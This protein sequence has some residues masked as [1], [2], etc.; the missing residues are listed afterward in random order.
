[1]TRH[2]QA[3]YQAD[4]DIRLNGLEPANPDGFKVEVKEIEAGFV[5]QDE[6]VKVTAFAVRHGSWKQAFG[7]R[8]ETADKTIVISGDAAPSESIAAMCQGC[9]ILVHE[10]YSTA[11]YATRE[12]EWQTYHASFHTSSKELAAIANQAK[13]GLLVLYHQLNWGVSDE[14][15]LAEIRQDYDGRVVS[16]SDLDVF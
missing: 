15:L 5:Y 11:G 7:Y 3:A 14:D 16:G 12:P 6:N 2:I 13:P 4:I 8:F 9:D 10:V 1:M